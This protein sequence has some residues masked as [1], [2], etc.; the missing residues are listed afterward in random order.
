MG[1]GSWNGVFG[2]ALSL[3]VVGKLAVATEVWPTRVKDFILGKSA[4]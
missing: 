1:I 3:A 2:V 4:G